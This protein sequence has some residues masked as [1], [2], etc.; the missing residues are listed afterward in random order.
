MLI[1]FCFSLT[2][3]ATSIGYID[4]GHLSIANSTVGEILGP[5][6]NQSAV[7]ASSIES[8]WIIL[9]LHDLYFIDEFS[10]SNYTLNHKG[11]WI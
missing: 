3:N 5:K 9:S 8:T 10:V 2:I 6:I 7:I 11:T 4:S 1:C